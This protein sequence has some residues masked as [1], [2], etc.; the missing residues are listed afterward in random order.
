MPSCPDA[1]LPQSQ[2]LQTGCPDSPT[3][4]TVTRSHK[5]LLDYKMPLGIIYSPEY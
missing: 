3:T 2:E 4:G 5:Y 1:Q